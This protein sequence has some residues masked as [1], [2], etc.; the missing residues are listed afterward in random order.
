[1]THPQAENSPWLIFFCW[2]IVRGFT[3]GAVQ[4]ESVVS[5]AVVAN[6][7]PQYQAH[8]YAGRRVYD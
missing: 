8:T 2:L 5:E 3:A 7:P 4:D 6:P 1:M